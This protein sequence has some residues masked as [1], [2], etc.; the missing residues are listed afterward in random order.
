MYFIMPKFSYSYPFIL[1]LINK[2]YLIFYLT[3]NLVIEIATEQT[4][5]IKAY[6]CCDK[7]KWTASQGSM[8]NKNMDSVYVLPGLELQLCHL[9][10]M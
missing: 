5:A 1:S 2:D 3:H 6:K 7:N 10:I 4:V 8:V 9:L